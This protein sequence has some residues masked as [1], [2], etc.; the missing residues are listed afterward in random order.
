[1]P[2]TPNRLAKIAAAADAGATVTLKSTEV[3]EL[4][5]AYRK[6]QTAPRS[7]REPVVVG[8][9]AQVEVT[10]TVAADDVGRYTHKGVGQVWAY[11]LASVAGALGI[12]EARARRVARGEVAGQQLRPS[13]LGDVLTLYDSLRR[14]HAAGA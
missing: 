14:P 4:L 3:R 8:D 9:L 1:M 13:N 2:L 5:R 12:S 7:R 6:G 11:D 10:V